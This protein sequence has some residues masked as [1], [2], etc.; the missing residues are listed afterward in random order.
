MMLII[1]ACLLI[2]PTASASLLSDMEEVKS[3]VGDYKAGKL[4]APQLVVNIEYAKN[5]MYEELDKEGRNSF[6]EQEIAAVFDKTNSE[7]SK[8]NWNSAQYEKKFKTDDFHVVF[9]ADSFFRHD[10]EYYEKREATAENY[11]SIGY[12]LVAIDVASGNL[13]YEI[14]DFISELKDLVSADGGSDDEYESARENLNKIKQ[15]VWEFREQEN[16][17]ELMKSVGMEE[18]EKDYPSDERSFYYL[19]DEDIEENCWTEDRCEWTCEDVEKCDESCPACYEEEV[20][21]EECEDVFNEETNST[22]NVCEDVCATENVCPECGENC[23]TEQNCYDKCEDSEEHCDEWSDGEV[24][25]EANCREDG[26]DLWLNS[27]GGKF[28]YYSGLNEGGEW[29]CENEM[30]SLVQMRKVLQKDFNQEFAEWYFEEYLAEDYDHM[31]NGA[32][33]FEHVL[34]LLTMNEE[35]IGENLYCSDTGQ[36]PD[37]F[38]KIDISYVNNNTH[39]EVWEKSIPVEWSQTPYYTTL[40]KYSWVPDRELLKELINYKLSETDT[41]GPSAKDVAEIKSDAGQMEIVNSLSERYGGSFDV[42]LELKDEQDQIVLKYLQVNPDVIVKITDSVEDKPD[43]SIEVEYDVLY[44]FISYMSYEME[45]DKIKGPHWVYVEDE[46]GPG[47]FFSVVGAVRKAW[48]EGVT[49]KPRYALLKLLFSSKD[50][51]G[52]ISGGDEESYEGETV[53]I[54]GEVIR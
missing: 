8:D 32:N 34:E 12:E 11:Y 21:S 20:C 43:I 16:C 33:G 54:S 13:E 40:Y 38:E 1:F 7:E 49:I 14:R 42:K 44:D 15:K 53:K 37:G 28:D 4:T 22:E 25:V 10:K 17:V 30:Q 46:D 19:I 52:L 47:K 31:I 18:R 41:F 39:V 26:S 6:T 2:I 5:K 48:K 9:R 50:I 24:G 29:N 23:W 27:W 3:Y 51:V 36:W 45:G 35:Q